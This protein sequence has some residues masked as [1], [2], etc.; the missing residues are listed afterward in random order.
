[1]QQQSY[2]RVKLSLNMAFLYAVTAGIHA[3]ACMEYRNGGWTSITWILLGFAS[4]LDGL[5]LY[6]IMQ[7]TLETRKRDRERRVV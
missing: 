4:L 2:P 7:S 6:L 3:W 5:M 1:M